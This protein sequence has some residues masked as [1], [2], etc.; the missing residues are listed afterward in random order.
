MLVESHWCFAWPRRGRFRN[1]AGAD[2]I[3]YGLRITNY[4]LRIGI[5]P[6]AVLGQLEG[7]CLLNHTGVSRGPEGADFVT[8]QGLTLWMS[9]ERGRGQ[10]GPFL[11]NRFRGLRTG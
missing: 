10:R 5:A 8:P 1:P 9:V 2:F 4:G 3:D 6:I 11:G 7:I